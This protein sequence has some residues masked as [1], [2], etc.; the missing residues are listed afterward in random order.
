MLGSI[1]G[2]FASRCQLSE[3]VIWGRVRS[4]P[5]CIHSRNRR[6]RSRRNGWRPVA[7]LG[8]GR[9]PGRI[10]HPGGTRNLRETRSIMEEKLNKNQG[11]VGGGFAE[12]PDEALLDASG[13]QKIWK[14]RCLMA[15][16]HGLSGSAVGVAILSGISPL[17]RGWFPLL[18]GA[19][20]V[21]RT[22]NTMVSNNT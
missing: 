7:V 22:T 20:V 2:T 14:P 4:N 8:W 11:G 6:A 12:I 9:G 10:C 1:H 17:V 15:L 3:W 19:V 16:L 13:G 5:L 18:I 21:R